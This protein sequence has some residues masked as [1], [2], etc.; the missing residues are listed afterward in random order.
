MRYA[1]LPK[2]KEA[3]K[4]A[5]EQAF[6]GLPTHRLLRFLFVAGSYRKTVGH[7]FRNL[8]RSNRQSRC[9][10]DLTIGETARRTLCVACAAK[11]LTFQPIEAMR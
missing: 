4:P 1:L 3:N 10:L 11:K 6:V 9:F 5:A 7:F 8:L 2:T